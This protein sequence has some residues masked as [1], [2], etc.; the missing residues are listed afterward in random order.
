MEGVRQ[1]LEDVFAEG[2]EGLDDGPG[3]AAVALGHHPHAEVRR[4]RR[5]QGG[6]GAEVRGDPVPSKWW[7]SAKFSRLCFS[8]GSEF[9]YLSYPAELMGKPLRE[10][11]TR[12][13]DDV[14]P[15]WKAALT[16]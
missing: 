3:A 10:R 16:G 11:E 5:A 9:F 14:D 13:P 4:Q 12:N 7:K 1:H 6:G 2:V 8:S 15:D